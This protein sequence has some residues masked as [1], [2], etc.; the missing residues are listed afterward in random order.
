MTWLNKNY[1][2]KNQNINNPLNSTLWQ[3]EWLKTQ[4]EMNLI[5][6]KIHWT[7]Q[8]RQAWFQLRDKNNKYFQTTAT[9]RKWQTPFEKLRMHKVTGLKTMKNFSANH[10]IFRTKLSRLIVNVA[11]KIFCWIL[12]VKS[13]DDMRYYNVAPRIFF[14]DCSAGTYKNSMRKKRMYSRWKL[15]LESGMKINLCSFRR[16]SIIPGSVGYFMKDHHAILIMAKG[17]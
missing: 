10:A 13:F 9:I 12:P 2:K 14:Q 4:L 15:M 3:V 11:S 7:Q 5:E 17:K 1:D 6:Q 8:A 16:H